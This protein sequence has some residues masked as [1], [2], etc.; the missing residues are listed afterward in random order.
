MYKIGELSKLCKMSVK[1]LRYYDSVGLLIPDKIDPFTDYRYYSAARLADC[2]RIVALKELGFSLD[3]ICQHLRADS[4]DSVVSLLNA[5]VNELQSFVTSTESQIRRLKAVKQIITEGDKQMFDVIIRN[6]DAISVAYVRQIFKTKEEAYKNT[7]E[8]K[9]NLPR[10]LTGARTLIINYETEYRESDFDLATCVEITAML[11]KDCSYE[12][13]TIAIS[14][15]VTSLVCKKDELEAAYRSMWKH[16]EENKMQIV[17]AFYEFYHDDGTV[18][19]KV[20][21]YRPAVGE[22]LEDNNSDLPFIN[23]EKALGK[24][25]LLDI[26]PSEEQFLYGHEKC[27][28]SGWLDELYFLENGEPY[29][30]INGWTKG[31]LFYRNP[32]ATFRHEYVIREY[33]GHN[34]L[35][36]KM[37]NYFD[38]EKKILAAPDIWIYEKVSDQKY[39]ASDIKRKDFV[40]YPFVV[41]ETIIGDWTA[42][43]FYK[44]VDIDK[45]NPEKRNWNSNSLFVKKFSFSSDGNCCRNQSI[46]EV[47]SKWTRGYVLDMLQ[48]LASAYEVR[49]INDTEY[50]II[51]WKSGDYVFGGR[52]PDYYVFIRA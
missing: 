46:R 27:K 21:V 3:E 31:F 29:W 14:G 38:R 44:S 47:K 40:N 35:F 8:M 32:D 22:S 23:D 52:K 13:K 18:E 7:E 26:V 4:T 39:H 19:L 34:L 12:G 15:D 24:W 49:L 37:K 9:N 25:T 10:Y 43:D 1:T 51:E 30:V 6:S 33:N 41:D 2:N 48:E 17:G 36:V 11:P 50:L 5:K 45:F 16:T 20:P 28:H 42:V